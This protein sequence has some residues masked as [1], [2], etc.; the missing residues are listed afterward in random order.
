MYFVNSHGFVIETISLTAKD[1]DSES[2]KAFSTSEEL[3]K[4]YPTITDDMVNDIPFLTIEE[5]E[6]RN[7]YVVSCR[8]NGR[9]EIDLSWNEDIEFWIETQ[10]ESFCVKDG[11]MF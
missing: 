11:V 4:A 6:D 9:G 1:I 2:V 3:Q 5:E 7:T 8:Y 10:K